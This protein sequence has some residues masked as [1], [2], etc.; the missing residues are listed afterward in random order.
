[1]NGIMSVFFLIN[2]KS[3]TYRCRQQWNKKE[4]NSI[5]SGS[6][7]GAFKN[8]KQEIKKKFTFNIGTSIILP[9]ES[10]VEFIDCKTNI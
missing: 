5:P 10:I 4:E 2:Y 7:Y 3:N 8:Y 6:F 1:M 9:Q